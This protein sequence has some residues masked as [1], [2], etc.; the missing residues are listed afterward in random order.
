M[1][2]LHIEHNSSSDL[3]IT[4]EPDILILSERDKELLGFG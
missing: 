1:K 3:L 4:D 2:G